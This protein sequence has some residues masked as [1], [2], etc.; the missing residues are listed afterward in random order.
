VK[1]SLRFRVALQMG[2]AM[3][4]ALGV[5]SLFGVYGA[6]I[7]LDRELNANLLNVASIQAGAVTD[8]PSGEMV[9]HEWDLTPAEAA[10]VRELNRYA[11]VWSAT[12]QSLLRTQYITQDLPLDSTSLH[13]A[14]VG[15]IVMTDQVFQD[16]PIRSLYYPLERMGAA[17]AMHVLQVAAPLTGRNHML[18]QLAWLL[19]GITLL[20]GAASFLGGWWLA[21]RVV[22]P[23]H[24][25]ID[26]AESMGAGTLGRR[27]EAD[28][29]EREHA[30]LIAVLN[31]MLARLEGAFE[32]QRRFIADASHELRS[33]I[34]ALKGEMEVA[35]RRDRSSDEYRRVLRSGLQEVDRIT[36]LTQDLLTL[37][38]VDAGVMQPRLQGTDAMER[39]EAVAERLR[40]LAEQDG[41]EVHVRGTRPVEVLADPVLLEQLL[42]NLV[43]N[44]I[45]F[46]PTGGRVTVTVERNGSRVVMTVRDTGPGIAEADRERIFERFYRADP[47]RTASAG[48]GGTGLGLAIVR[49][50]AEVHG[51]TVAAANHPAGGAVFEAS[52]PAVP[53]PRHG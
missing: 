53:G 43:E 16:M 31:S 19:L 47:A 37:A 13:A 41:V 2:V 36:L 49:A 32:S 28:V 5:L 9:F 7:F 3:T 34:T 38:R 20:S 17:H 40:P 35:L 30:R 52:L 6:S 14:A 24:E 39:A 4:S 10:Q 48:P 29:D 18:R 22:R 33:P 8:A 11:Q 51:G 27:I 25:I 44:A 46:T 15:H 42:W 21:A 23:V 26:Q 1:R 45:K 12:G 50:I